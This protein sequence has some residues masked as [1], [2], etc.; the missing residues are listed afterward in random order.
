MPAGRRLQPS[1]Y[2][3]S[4]DDTLEITVWKEPQLSGVLA[5]RPDGR[6]SIAGVGDIIAAGHTAH[7]LEAVI[8]KALTQTISSPMVSVAVKESGAHIY[9]LGEVGKPGAYPLHGSLTVLQALALAGG[10]TEFAN[11]G[12]IV[13]LRAVDGKQVRYQFSYGQ[14][15]G[16]DQLFDLEPGDT[17]VVP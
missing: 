9:V 4:T 12:R 1:E 7:E 5:V 8:G 13:V 14:A 3:I 10:L 6:V 17:I 16:G 15:V 2:R 11:G